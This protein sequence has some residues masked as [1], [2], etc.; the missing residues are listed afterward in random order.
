ML[1]NNTY[2]TC[3]LHVYS[4]TY[5]YSY[6]LY[7]LWTQRM[8]A[9]A[10]IILQARVMHIIH[11]NTYVHSYI[12]LHEYIHTSTY[13][14]IVIF[15]FTTAAP[16]SKWRRSRRRLPR[17]VCKQILFVLRGVSLQGLCPMKKIQTLKQKK[18]SEWQPWYSLETGDIED[19]LQGVQW[20]L[21]LSPWRPFRFSDRRITIEK[22][23]VAQ[24]IYI[25]IYIYI[26]EHASDW[27]LGHHWSGN[28]F[29]LS[30]YQ[31]ITRT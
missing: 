2:A 20:T 5:T 16:S 1:T 19:Q 23:F 9:Y 30:R 27:E 4:N 12:M 7:I 24:L 13:S 17:V 26:Y 14:W 8:D 15:N 31:A 29:S 22:L 21:W 25:Y 3:H 11:V 18:S 28:G 10:F 6:S